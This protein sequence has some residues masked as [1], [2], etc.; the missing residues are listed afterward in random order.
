[1]AHKRGVTAHKNSQRPRAQERAQERA[2]GC[3]Q[4]YAG[5]QQILPEVPYPQA[6]CILLCLFCAYIAGA[7]SEQQPG[8]R[9]RTR[10]RTSLRLGQ[11]ARTR[12]RTRRAQGRAHLDASWA[13]LGP[14]W[15]FQGHAEAILGQSRAYTWGSTILWQSWAHPAAILGAQERAQECAQEHIL[16][17]QRSQPAAYQ[18]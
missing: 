4:A 7:T 9:A 14:S 3:A 15:S 2:Q 11:N 5:E 18:E 12:A 1:M 10:M 6:V 16:R 13:I 17:G 8:T